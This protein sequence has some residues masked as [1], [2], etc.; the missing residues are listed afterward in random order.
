MGLWCCDKGSG[1]ESDISLEIAMRAC[2]RYHVV[3][4]SCVVIRIVFVVVV[5]FVP[6]RSGL[7]ILNPRFLL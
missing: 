1:R 6:K 4:K 5:D 7:M 2:L 3:A